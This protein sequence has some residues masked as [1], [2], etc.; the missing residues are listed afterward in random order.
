MNF[1]KRDIIVAIIAIV[2]VIVIISVVINKKNKDKGTSE[3]TSED[4][5]ITYELDENTAEY[6]IYDKETGTE[7]TRVDEEGAVKT[8]E[9]NPDF[10]P[11]LN[12]S[13]PSFV[14]TN[15]NGFI[16]FSSGS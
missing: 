14:D 10:D 6:V 13:D 3:Q 11:K 2:L 7:I 1:E 12:S 15:G 5:N 8:F 16:D 9:E 4:T